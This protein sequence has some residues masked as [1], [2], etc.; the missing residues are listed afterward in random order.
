M[1][2]KI[3]KKL[4]NNYKLFWKNQEKKSNKTK[5]FFTKINNLSYYLNF[6]QFQHKL[7]H[8]PGFSVSV[9]NSWL[10]K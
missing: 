6:L 8:H 4:K 2:K 9:G 1:K 10:E 3:T 5:R 7:T